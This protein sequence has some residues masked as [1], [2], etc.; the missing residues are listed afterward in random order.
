MSRVS[1]SLAQQHTLSK[2][3]SG[4]RR[5]ATGRPSTGHGDVV[6]HFH[7]IAPIRKRKLFLICTSRAVP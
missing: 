1:T 7:A 2:S 3:G 6:A 5:R 4:N